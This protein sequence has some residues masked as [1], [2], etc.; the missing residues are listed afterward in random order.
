MGM[1]TILNNPKTSFLKEPKVFHE[2]HAQAQMPLSQMIREIGKGAKKHSKTPEKTD[3][4]KSEERLKE[5]E[6]KMK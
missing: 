3:A 1:E 6:R 4:E 2:I 5:M